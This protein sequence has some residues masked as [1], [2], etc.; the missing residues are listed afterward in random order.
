MKREIRF[1][2]VK[3]KK[4]R[5]KFQTVQKEI[6]NNEPYL[7]VVR[8]NASELLLDCLLFLSVQLCNNCLH[9]LGL[10]DNDKGPNDMYNIVR[11]ILNIQNRTWDT[12]CRVIGEINYMA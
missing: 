1:Q 10:L 2:M 11:E 12:W 4:K 5:I 3:P 8:M 6:K 7:K 9:Y